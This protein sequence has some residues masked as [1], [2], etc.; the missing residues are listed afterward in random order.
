MFTTL[1]EG[2][3]DVNRSLDVDSVK[4][5]RVSVRRAHRA[6]ACTVQSK[7]QA[8]LL[9]SY[10]GFVSFETQRPQTARGVEVESY[11]G[12]WMKRQKKPSPTG[13]ESCATRKRVDVAY[14]GDTDGRLLTT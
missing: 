5:V 12:T 3:L 10:L 11:R 2:A 13:L 8:L 4:S 6:A 1:V 14:Q 7:S 9:P